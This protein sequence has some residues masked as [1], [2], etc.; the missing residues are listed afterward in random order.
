MAFFDA[1]QSFDIALSEVDLLLTKAK[2]SEQH[3]H[4]YL[5]FIK[6]AIVLLG[7]KFENYAETI[8]ENYIDRLQ[9]L[10][11]KT[12]H[13]PKEL[14]ISSTTLLLNQCIGNNGFSGKPQSVFNLHTAASMWSD[15]HKHQTIKISNKFSYGKH[16]S[17]EMKALFSRIGISDIFI[18]CQLQ[19]TEDDSMLESEPT[20]KSISPDMDSFTNIR[21]NIIHSD[22]SPNITHQQIH[23]Y[24]EKFWEFSYLVDLKLQK[25]IE[26]LELIISRDP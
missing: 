20:K 11:P 22:S 6:A 21:N 23:N 1:T 8:V 4:D 19:H 17:G 16:G 14:R 25:K 3:L 13:L 24:K 5:T 26:E 12:K 7:A 9:Q 2:Q 15:E 18:E 10:E